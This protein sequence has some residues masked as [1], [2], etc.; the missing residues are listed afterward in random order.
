MTVNRLPPAREPEPDYD[1]EPNEFQIIQAKQNALATKKVAAIEKAHLTDYINEEL[2]RKFAQPK[3][4]WAGSSNRN[5]GSI[6]IVYNSK[7]KKAVEET[8]EEIGVSVRLG[9]DYDRLDHPDPNYYQYCSYI[10]PANISFT[11]LINGE[12]KRR[13][14]EANQKFTE[15]VKAVGS[16]ALKIEVTGPMLDQIRADVEARYLGG[17]GQGR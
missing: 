1:Q 3:H 14:A 6:A 8:L 11:K 4:T 17:R 15:A 5:G 12:V 2:A 10:D 16:N 13:V 9:S 7:E